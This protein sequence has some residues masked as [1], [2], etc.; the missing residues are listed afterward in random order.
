MKQWLRVAMGAV[1]ILPMGEMAAD[2]PTPVT[3]A[4]TKGAAARAMARM[5]LSV[6]VREAVV[7]EGW[8]EAKRD[9]SGICR[10]TRSYRPSINSWRRKF[11]PLTFRYWTG[12]SL[13]RRVKSTPSS[14]L[15]KARLMQ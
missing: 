12:S 5:Q 11:L 7:I 8:S 15:R 14:S 2:E 3:E 10:Q 1:V 4:S 9:A 13:H 6:F